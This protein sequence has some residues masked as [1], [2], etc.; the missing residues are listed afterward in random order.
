MHQDQKH[1]RFAVLADIHIDLENGGENTYFIHAQK[2]FANALKVIKKSGCA[3]IVSA[4]DQ[5]T[6]ASGAEEEWQKYREIIDRSG[7]QGQIFEAMGNHE[8]RL[9]KRIYPLCPP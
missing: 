1:Y 5:V 4:G 6:N 7:Y 9:Q 3:F 2:N 8:T